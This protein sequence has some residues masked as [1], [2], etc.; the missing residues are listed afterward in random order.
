MSSDDKKIAAIAADDIRRDLFT[1]TC[2][3]LFTYLLKHKLIKAKVLKEDILM[4]HA[5]KNIHTR[6]ADIGMFFYKYGDWITFGAA[7]IF[8]GIGALVGFSLKTVALKTAARVI[9][10]AAVGAGLGAAAA[11][12]GCKT[13]GNQNS[14]YC[15]NAKGEVCMTIDLRSQYI[16][17]YR[18]IAL[19]TL[20]KQYLVS[21]NTC[22]HWVLNYDEFLEQDDHLDK[23]MGRFEDNL[24]LAKKHVLAR[25]NDA[26]CI[27]MITQLIADNPLDELRKQCPDDLF[28]GSCFSEVSF[29]EKAKFSFLGLDKLTMV[30]QCIQIFSRVAR[31][32][33]AMLLNRYYGTV[34][35]CRMLSL[36][37]RVAELQKALHIISGDVVGPTVRAMDEAKQQSDEWYEELVHLNT[38]ALNTCEL[39]QQLEHDVHDYH[40]FSGAKG[41]RLG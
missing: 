15:K 31:I 14:F 33:R 13:W 12:M 35:H 34:D 27:A 22:L 9:T 7:I 16:G 24:H 30:G 25:T 2:D 8:G 19:L 26:V 40:S 5:L 23:I 17:T 32:V 1:D 41:V 37:T 21:C 38:V 28:E 4:R 18:L 10:G 6:A 11:Y 20:L 29:S 3:K 39:L 36:S